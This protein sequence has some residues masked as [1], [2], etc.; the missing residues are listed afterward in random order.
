MRDLGIIGRCRFC[1]F[2]KGCLAEVGCS[3][4]Q[5]PGARTSVDHET[6]AIGRNAIGKR[7]KTLNGERNLALVDN[8]SFFPVDLELEQVAGLGIKP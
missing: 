3:V 1:F 7:A 4:Q 5:Q 8:R 6:A 2:D